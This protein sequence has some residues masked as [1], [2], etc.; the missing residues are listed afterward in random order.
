M[1]LPNAGKSSLFTALT[2]VVP[3]AFAST[4]GVAFVPDDRLTALAE[5]SKS[6]KVVQ[7]TMEWVDIPGLVAGGEGAASRFLHAIREVDAICFVLGAFE[8]TEHDPAAALEI[9]E[10]ELVV[11]DATSGQSQ[12]DKRR[13]MAKSD[14]SLLPEVAALEKA[15]AILDDGIP[16]YRASLSAEDLALLKN[17]FLLT[18]RRALVVVNVAEGDGAEVI[19]PLAESL[20]GVAEVLAVNADFEQQLRDLDAADQ[21]EFLADQG[22]TEA[23]LPRWFGPPTS[24]WAGARS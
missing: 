22:L 12:L 3:D 9:L 23:A 16:L 18:T 7:A 14:K 8:E 20:R 17:F 11:A 15:L 19:A 24:C 21:A 5:M 6:K 10:L 13:K 2:G 4:V 1:G